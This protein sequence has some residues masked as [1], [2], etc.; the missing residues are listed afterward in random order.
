MNT[1]VNSSF[2]ELGDKIF[3]IGFMG[4]GKT[5]WGKIWAAKSGL[6]FF[7][8][9]EVIELEEKKTVAEIFSQ[10]GEAYFRQKEMEMLQTFATKQ[11]CIVACG[12]GTPCF[13]NNMQWMNAN[14]TTVY[15]LA[16]AKEIFNRVITEQQKRPLIKDFSPQELLVFI[17]N[18]LQEREI[19][20]SQAKIILPAS[21]IKA[22]SINSIL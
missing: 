1:A 11:N 18:K 21:A 22:D 7:D 19:Y 14:G 4:S 9:D 2:R 16:T 15:L 20:Y 12:G 6:Q 17:E 5:H 13:N 8:L 3:L 10:N